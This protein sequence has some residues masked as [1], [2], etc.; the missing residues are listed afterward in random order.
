MDVLSVGNATIDVF[1]LLHNLQKF[2]YDKFTNQI[3]FPLGEKVPLDEYKLTLGGNACNVSV[4]LS[5]LGLKTSLAAQ[6]GNDEFSDKIVNTLKKENVDQTNIDKTKRETPYFNIVLAYEGERT[7]LEEKKP[8]SGELIITNL[9]PKLIYLSSVSG[10]WKKVYES[11]FSN[12]SNS[13]FAFNPGARQISEYLDEVINI[14]PKLEILFVNLSEAQRLTGDTNPD[15]KVIIEKLSNLG[16]KISVLTDGTN[17]SYVIDKDGKIYKIGVVSEG[18]PIERTGAG[19]SYAAGFIYG[20]L[21]GKSVPESMKLGT[22]NAGS[23]I[24]KIG[25]QDGLLTKEEMEQKFNELS[26]LSA[27]ELQ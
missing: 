25:A 22:I 1:V 14:L 8:D 26:E 6:V 10:N 2:S 13:L 17:G 23:V 12:N 9:N 11:V 20:I 21:S 4:G 16:P 18:K 27:S 15:I 5:R 7:V 19:D 24:K 3:Y